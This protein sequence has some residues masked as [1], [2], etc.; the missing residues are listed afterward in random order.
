[1]Q[2]PQKY[3]AKVVNKASLCWK[4]TQLTLEFIEPSE[5]TFEPGQ[6]VSLMVG[7]T[8]FR[9]YSICSDYKDTTS[10]SL[11]I[12]TGHEGKGSNFT[13][14]LNLGDTVT[15]I[16]PSGRYRLKQPYAQNIV[17]LAT[18][19]GIA[20]FVPMLHKLIDD[21]FEGKVTL[22]Q[23]FRKDD[24]AFFTDLFEFFKSKL[25]NF[26]YKIFISQSTSNPKFLTGRINADLTQIIKPDAHY[27]ICGHPNMVAETKKALIDVVV[28]PENVLTEEFTHSDKS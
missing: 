14:A 8:I 22:F 23:G 15:F 1:M 7:D 17:F 20:P 5:L 21:N 16:G 26:D 10:L 2:L 13:R 24:D 3:T 12:E 11:I 6:F 18:G 19:T 25:T 28:D 4:V 9:A 27:Y